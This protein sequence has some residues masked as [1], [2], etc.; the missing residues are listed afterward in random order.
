MNTI[1]W[2]H[3]YWTG[4]VCLLLLGDVKVL[5]GKD[6]NLN[7]KHKV[8][9]SL[10]ITSDVVKE[11][12]ADNVKYLELRTTPRN[13]ARMTKASY[14]DSVLKA[15]RD[16]SAGLDIVVRLLLSVDRQSSLSD[17]WDTFKMVEA[18][19]MKSENIVVGID[20]CGNPSVSCFPFRVVYQ[21]T[22]IFV[23]YTCIVLYKVEINTI[24]VVIWYW[25]LPTLRYPWVIA[26]LVYRDIT[27]RSNDPD[28]MLR[29]IFSAG[30]ITSS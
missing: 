11:F 2:I 10:Q 7:W 16:S 14:V 5:A 23:C 4:I 28:L 30:S 19:T 21:V 26:S 15:I 27:F 8:L 25:Q 1:L 13:V 22:F 12:A 29:E 24:S 3:H 9:I 6:I 20:F 18:Y 17:A